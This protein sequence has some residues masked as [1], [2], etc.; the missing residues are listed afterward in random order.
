M[1]RRTYRTNHGKRRQPRAALALLLLFAAGTAGAEELRLGLRADALFLPGE[2]AEASPFG[3]GG[4]LNAEVAGLFGTGLCAGLT[5]GGGAF[6]PA[7]DRIESLAMGKAVAELGWRFPLGKSFFLTPRLGAGV[8]LLSASRA[9]TAEAYAANEY[10]RRTGTQFSGEA[11]CELGFRPSEAWAISLTPSY[12]FL[13]ESGGAYHG[14]GVSLGASLKLR[15][16]ARGPSAE[17]RAR[18]EKALAKLAAEKNVRTEWRGADLVVVLEGS[19]SGDSA[20]L[21]GRTLKQLE[22][23]AEAVRQ[24]RPRRLG[25]EGYVAADQ[26]AATDAKVSTARAEAVRARL[27][28]DPR[29]KGLGLAIAAAGR[30]RENPIADNGTEEGRLRNRRVE[31]LLTPE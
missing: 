9:P 3:A 14:I 29:L 2:F 11:A 23:L 20:D 25:V 8:S 28:A 19:F 13:G 24:L 12:V 4:S 17:T 27:L 15:Q 30:G 31:V 6:V 10:S 21:T 7:D 5:A 16:F 18:T 22:L 1:N 26:E